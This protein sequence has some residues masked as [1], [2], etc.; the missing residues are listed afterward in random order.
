MGGARGTTGTRGC[1][2]WKTGYVKECRHIKIRMAASAL[3]GKLLCSPDQKCPST[4]SLEPAGH[5]ILPSN[6]TQAFFILLPL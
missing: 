6:S 4:A 3:L 5:N 2:G 1:Y